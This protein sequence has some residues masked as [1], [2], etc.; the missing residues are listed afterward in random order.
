MGLVTGAVTS[1]VSQS[2]RGLCALK[3]LNLENLPLSVGNWRCSFVEPYSSVVLK[4]SQSM[5]YC[6]SS[7]L[8]QHGKLLGIF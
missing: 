2:H 7:P 8:I 3:Y 1:A 4:Q 5:L 6:L